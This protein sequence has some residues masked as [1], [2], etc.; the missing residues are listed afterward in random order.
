[1]FRTV[2]LLGLGALWLAAPRAQAADSS[3]LC[4]GCELRLGIGATYHFWATTQG[5]V[6]PLTLT[7]SEN[8]YEV[9]IF[10]M[11]TSQ[12][13]TGRRARGMRVAE[14]YWGL[15]ASRRWN[16]V[17]QESWRVFAGFGASYKTESDELSVTHWNF[18]SQLGLRV[19]VAG[20]DSAVELCLRHWSNA[21]LRLP[22][23]GQDF[24][25]VSY[26]F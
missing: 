5:V 6:V 1:M 23:H 8:R 9:G 11:A 17:T 26:T 21:G 13:L 2:A 24:L 12:I 25:T 14:P 10:R 22:N 16:L 19:D 18:A 3:Y 4:E 20:R 7:W 15:S